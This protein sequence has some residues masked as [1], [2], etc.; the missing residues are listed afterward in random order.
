VT[1]HLL[2]MSAVLPIDEVIG[3]SEEDKGY[4]SR[5]ALR[6]NEQFLASMRSITDMKDLVL[7][8][9]K[10]SYHQYQIRYAPN[11]VMNGGKGASIPENEVVVKEQRCSANGKIGGSVFWMK[12]WKLPGKNPAKC[13]LSMFKSGQPRLIEDSTGRAAR[14]NP[15]VHIDKEIVE[16]DTLKIKQFFRQAECGT[17]LSQFCNARGYQLPLPKDAELG[18]EASIV[19]EES[20]SEEEYEEVDS[21]EKCEEIDEEEDYQFLTPLDDDVSDKLVQKRKQPVTMDQAVD[22][23]QPICDSQDATPLRRSKRLKHVTPSPDQRK[24]LRDDDNAIT[25]FIDMGDDSAGWKLIP[26]MRKLVR[27]HNV[28]SYY[29]YYVGLAAVN[30]RKDGKGSLIPRGGLIIEERRCSSNH[31]EEGR[32][33][34][35]FDWELPQENPGTSKEKFFRSA[36]PQLLEKCLG[37]HVRDCPVVQI[38]DKIPRQDRDIIVEFFDKAEP[39][40]TLEQFCEGHGYQVATVV[41]GEWT[42]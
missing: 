42:F 10:G 35:L 18:K 19:I 26:E 40:T 39:A 14:D 15:V 31:K 8:L 24:M 34:S 38:S 29:Q 16:K 11:S 13:R 9:D 3:D 30:T 32:V 2:P 22:E 17:T 20:D 5:K 6:E 7:S 4:V 28:G 12:D 23:V 25:P 21:E 27:R 37:K 36:R 41:L 33:M 1:E